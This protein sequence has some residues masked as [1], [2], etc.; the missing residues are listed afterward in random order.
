MK[1]RLHLAEKAGHGPRGARVTAAHLGGGFIQLVPETADRV[2][3]FG[4]VPDRAGAGDF[5][6]LLGGEFF[7]GLSL[8]VI[9]PQALHK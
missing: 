1:L 6:P 5:G 8:F 7:H 9:H 3:A 2:L 4:H